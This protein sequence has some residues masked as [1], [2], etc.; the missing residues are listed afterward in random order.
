MPRPYMARRFS[1]RYLTRSLNRLP[2]HSAFH[3]SSHPGRY[4]APVLTSTT[5]DTPNAI[6]VTAAMMHSLLAEPRLRT[7]ATTNAAPTTIQNAAST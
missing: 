2:T 7:A 4:H 6:N 1:I 3:P 5:S